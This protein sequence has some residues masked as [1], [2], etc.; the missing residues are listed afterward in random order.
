MKKSLLCLTIIVTGALSSTTFAASGTKETT[1]GREGK[2]G[3]AARGS[4]PI[5]RF[6]EAITRE[7]QGKFDRMEQSDKMQLRAIL[8][9]ASPNLRNATIETDLGLS[10]LGASPAGRRAI[11]DLVNKTADVDVVKSII[12]V[13]ALKQSP[14]LTRIEMDVCNKIFELSA[15]IPGYV[16]EGK[17]ING[18]KATKS[19]SNIERPESWGELVELVLLAK[20]QGRTDIVKFLVEKLGEQKVE[21]L[22]KCKI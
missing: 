1:T 6:R 15:E 17:S 14:E 19:S 20:K 3:T 16:K 18:E 8:E 4:D 10:Y 13:S 11:S 21:E 5:E 2:A 22:L 12:L 9:K 7:E